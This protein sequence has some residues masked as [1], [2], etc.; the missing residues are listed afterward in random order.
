MIFVISGRHDLKG[1]VDRDLVQREI[2]Y[3][4]DPGDVKPIFSIFINARIN[5]ATHDSVY[6]TTL[7]P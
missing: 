3:A 5:H 2:G 1:R 6:S 4:L 7:T